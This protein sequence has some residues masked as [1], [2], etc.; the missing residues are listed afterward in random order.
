MI[1]YDISRSKKPLLFRSFT[2]LAVQQQFDDIYDKEMAKDMTDIKFNAYPK[3]IEKKKQR[4][5]QAFP[6]RYQR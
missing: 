4:W 2:H 6:T 5:K 3:K 1:S